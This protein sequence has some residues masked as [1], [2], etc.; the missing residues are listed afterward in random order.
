[1]RQRSTWLGPL[2]AGQYSPPNREARWVCLNE[3]LNLTSK[4]DFQYTLLLDI[5][6]MYNFGNSVDGGDNLGFSVKDSRHFCILMLNPSRISL[7]LDSKSHRKYTLRLPIPTLVRQQNM[8]HWVGYPCV[9]SSNRGLSY[10]FAS[11]LL[12]S[13]KHMAHATSDTSIGVSC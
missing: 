12:Y 6:S 11:L 2:Q 4:Y 3:S 8:R 10:K 1:M 5:C 13:P 7:R 9:D